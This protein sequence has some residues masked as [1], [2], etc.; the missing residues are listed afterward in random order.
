[1]KDFEEFCKEERETIV[2]SS[3]ED[4]YKTFLDNSE[5]DLEKKFGIK[6]NFQTSTRG[7]KIRGVY[8]T[9]EEA[10]LRC[11]MLREVDPNHDIMV[12][13]VGLWMPWDPEAYKTGRIEYMEEE[14]N[15]LMN[16][17]KKNESNAKMAFDQRVK[18]TKQKAIEDNIKNA[19]KTGNSLTQTIDENGNLIGVGTANTQESFLKSNENISVSDIRN[20]LFEGENIVVGETDYGRSQLISGPFVIKKGDGVMENTD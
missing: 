13:P 17:K 10:E 1:M 5:E 6:H 11:K 9:M 19:E 2:S 12:G 3:I 16:E 18:E 15:Q 14:L 8:P 4:D 7:V 20:E